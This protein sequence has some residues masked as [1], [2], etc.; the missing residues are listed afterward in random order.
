I[1]ATI[2]IAGLTNAYAQGP[3]V[4]AEYLECVILRKADG[5][6]VTIGD[7]VSGDYAANLIANLTPE[8]SVPAILQ[9]LIELNEKPIN[10]ILEASISFVPYLLLQD[11]DWVLSEGGN[12]EQVD[13]DWFYN[14][15]GNSPYW[16]AGGWPSI[17]GSGDCISYCDVGA[18]AEFGCIEIAVPLL[19][20][21]GFSA[22]GCDTICL[23]TEGVHCGITVKSE[24]LADW[25]GSCPQTR[26]VDSWITQTCWAATA[27]NCASDGGD[28][29]C[30]E[31]FVD[32]NPDDI[33]VDY[34]CSDKA[35]KVHISQWQT[36]FDS[37]GPIFDFCYPV[38]QLGLFPQEGPVFDETPDVEDIAA[39]LGSYLALISTVADSNFIY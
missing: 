38:T 28:V 16:F 17:Y 12:F 35:V 26:G 29:A 11:G 37:I 32:S 34:S 13:A 6:E 36:L 9:V 18:G 39:I 4:Y 23:P 2:I 30:G 33:V 22:E 8:Q 27:N 5:T 24:D 15:N 7:I 1:P 14:G 3:D 31:P 25:T 21:T 20:T 10:V 19:D